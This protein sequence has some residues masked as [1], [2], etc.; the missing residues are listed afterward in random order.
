MENIYSYN[1]FGKRT[2]WE[3]RVVFKKA[4]TAAFD[5]YNEIKLPR[6]SFQLKSTKWEYDKYPLGL[7]SAKTLEAEIKLSLLESNIYNDFVDM[8][9]NPVLEVNKAIYVTSKKYLL[10]TIIEFYIKF[11]NNAE[12]EVNNFRKIMTGIILE[13]S[14][15]ESTNALE[16]VY[17]LKAEDINRV[18]LTQSSLVD[19]NAISNS[20]DTERA[21]Y[22]DYYIDSSPK[23]AIVHVAG[24]N[25]KFL[26]QPLTTLETYIN[27]IAQTLYRD[28]SRNHTA[29]YSIEL[30]IPRIY[31]QVYNGSGTRGSE[32]T[33]NEIYLLTTHFY[34]L[35]PLDGLYNRD[36]EDSLQKNYQSVWDFLV[37]YYTQNL[38]RA[39]TLPDGIIS[40][41]IFG[42][43]GAELTVNVDVSKIEIAY[44]QMSNL[45][46]KVTSSM[47]ESRGD[48]VKDID[49]FVAELTASRNSNEYTV[50]ITFNTMPTQ[51]VN[52]RYDWLV[53]KGIPDEYTPK[54]WLNSIG[55]NSNSNVFGGYD[56][57]RYGLYYKEQASFCNNAEMFRVHEYTSLI[58]QPGLYTENIIPHTALDMSTNDFTNAEA[59]IAQIQMQSSPQIIA[60]S[61]LK[62]FS[63][64][65]QHT[66]KLKTRI[67][68]LTNFQSGGGTGYI[69][70]EPNTKLIINLSDIDSRKNISY[71]Q[72]YIVSSQIDYQE[73]IA[74]LEIILK[75]I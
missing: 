26:F 54:A 74:E 7:H 65:E 33:K 44:K 43:S 41:P 20:N 1:W 24:Y 73:E 63:K 5:T 49:N 46:K 3:Y 39:W 52:Y 18:L 29:N 12:E 17:K 71:N 72:W 32:L 31:K 16:N 25:E 58:L 36:D 56:Y 2:G 8:L 55:I 14:E 48:K 13:D 69:W 19:L 15:V 40:A 62:I 59:I 9:Y 53:K 68:Y 57:R 21:G 22:I 34:D 42:N 66:A 51:D 11:N 75:V 37:D 60:D 50:P 35:T 61:I 45:L 47:T 70:D 10:G 64:K 27:G 67:E 38:K 4:S 6:G 30:P 23:K 28:L